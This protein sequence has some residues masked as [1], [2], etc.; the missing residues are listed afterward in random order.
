MKLGRV[1][2]TLLIVCLFSSLCVSYEFD[3]SELSWQIAC[4][5]NVPVDVCILSNSTSWLDSNYTQIPFKNSTLYTSWL[6]AAVPG[7]VLANLVKNNIY[8]DPYYS[9]NNELI[10]DLYNVPQEFYTFWYYTSFSLLPNPN[11][12]YFL[13]LRFVN[14]FHRNKLFLN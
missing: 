6:P 9:L 2:R 4:I 11:E 13:V 1:G 14:N 8:P 12:N 5:D 3:L 7:T 10:P